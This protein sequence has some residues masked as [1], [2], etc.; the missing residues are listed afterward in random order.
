MPP[1]SLAAL[2]R[3][4]VRWCLC[5]ALAPTNAARAEPDHHALQLAILRAFAG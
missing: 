5:D 2:H 4:S 3:L 1:V